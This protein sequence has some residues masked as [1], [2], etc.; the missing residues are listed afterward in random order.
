MTKTSILLFLLT[1]FA[2]GCS[3]APQEKYPEAYGLYAWNGNAWIE[4][5]K[6]KS[7]I[8]LDL[9]MET[10]FLIHDKAIDRVSK[11][12]RL[13]QNVYIRS[14]ITQDPNGN[15]RVINP[16]EKWDVIK[17]SD[18]IDGRFSPVKGQ[19]E[20]VTWVPSSKLATGVYTPNIE[21]NF[22]EAFTVSRQIVLTKTNIEFSDSCY[23]QIIVKFF[24]LPT[25]E[26]DRYVPCAG[27]PTEQLIKVVSKAARNAGEGKST[28]ADIDISRIE[29]LL[30][31]Q[32]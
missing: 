7:T 16:Y 9:P 27:N 2:I 17:R 11:G 20:M 31:S 5:A 22:Q 4:V 14:V 18:E 24:G 8:E 30:I 21:G 6:E 28:P 25:G 19:P 29:K 13:I 32:K 1:L 10:R 12:F 15:N 3:K 26:E 23:D